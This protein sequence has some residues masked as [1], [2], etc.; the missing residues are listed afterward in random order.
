MIIGSLAAAFV[1]RPALCKDKGC[2]GCCQA[3]QFS[4][5]IAPPNLILSAA[6]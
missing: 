2:H 4:L 5:R 1:S 6:E 3:W